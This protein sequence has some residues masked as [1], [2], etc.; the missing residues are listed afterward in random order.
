VDLDGVG[1]HALGHLGGEQLGHRGFLE[2]GLAGVLA[3]AA[4]ASTSWRA[5]SSWVAMSARRKL[6]AWCSMIGLPKVSRSWA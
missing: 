5:A 2:A 1:A 4:R 6:T 3:Q